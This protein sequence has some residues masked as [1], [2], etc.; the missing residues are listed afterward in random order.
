MC[1]RAISDQLQHPK[2]LI[3]HSLHHSHEE[4]VS[5]P[6]FGHEEQGK[7]L[8]DAKGDIFRGLEVVPWKQIHETY[9]YEI[10]TPTS[11]KTDSGKYPP[12]DVRFLKF[13]SSSVTTL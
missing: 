4:I 13:R 8:A 3:K 12:R 6:T 7:T 9:K 2:K 5:F 1:N 10:H 11:Q